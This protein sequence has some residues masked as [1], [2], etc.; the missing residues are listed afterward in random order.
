MEFPIDQYVHL[1][2]PGDALCIAV[3]VGQL[4]AL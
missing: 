1:G 3:V 4:S 2:L